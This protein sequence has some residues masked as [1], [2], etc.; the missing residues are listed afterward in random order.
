[1]SAPESFTSMPNA[2]RRVVITGLGVMAPNG[3]GTETWWEATKAGTS[4]IGRITHFDPSQYP[5]QL[6]GEVDGFDA[7]EYLEQRMI[8]Q[9][10]RWTHMALA[11]TQMALEDAKF[12]PEGKDPYRMSVITASASGGN[13]FGQKEIENLWGKGPI[14][15]GAYQSIAWFYAATTGQIAIKYGMKGPCGVVVQEG[16][17]GL[18]ALWHS[19]RNIIRGVDF[20]VSGGVEAPIGPYALTCQLTNGR[21]SSASEPKAAYRPFDAA[22]NGYVPGEGGAIIIVEESG[23]ATGRGAPQVYGEIIGYGTTNDAYD[24]KRPTP[25][26]GQLARAM[27]LALD[28]AGVDAGDVDAVFADAS[29]VPE[30]D[31]AEVDA[32]KDVF[33]GREV[34]VTAPKTMTGRL[35]AGSGALDVAAA[36][37]AMRDGVLPPTI[38][39]SRPAKGNNLNFVTGEARQAELGTVL[40]N[41]RGFGGFNSAMVLGRDSG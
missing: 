41:A 20:V 32:I 3:I 40:V 11:A 25:N 37:L 31:R 2:D 27:R 36:L 28:R 26:G 4:G 6:A 30:S 21:L 10:D 34:P 14:F 23:H 17:G 22:A 8:V 5:T 19:R 29:G 38:N 9:T 13:E 35:Y 15:V 1:M 16:A 7:S 12:E 33:G 18:E 39:L 24:P